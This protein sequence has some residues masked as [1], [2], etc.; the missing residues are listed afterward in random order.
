MMVVN[1]HIFCAKLCR[2]LAC[3]KLQLPNTVR[4]RSDLTVEKLQRNVR[5]EL[6]TNKQWN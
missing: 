2:T 4:V 1:C 3:W 5:I 6:K